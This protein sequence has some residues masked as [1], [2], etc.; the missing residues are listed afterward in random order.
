MTSIEHI[1]NALLMYLL[2]DTNH[3]FNQLTRKE[4]A[5]VRNQE[6]LN[7]LIQEITGGKS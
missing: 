7:Q 5:I 3:D 4:K 6:T 2:E 1:K